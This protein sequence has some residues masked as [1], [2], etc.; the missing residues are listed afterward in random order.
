[1]SIR[2]RLGSLAVLAE[3]DGAA[4]LGCAV[5]VDRLGALH[6]AGFRAVSASRLRAGSAGRLRVSLLSLAAGAALLLGGAAHAAAP[7]ESYLGAET[8]SNGNVLERSTAFGGI[9]VTSVV[10]NSP[11]EVAGLREGDVI[12]RA[13]GI[14]ISHP[15]RLAE[16]VEKLP[17]GSRIRFR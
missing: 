15:I 11:A 17:P 5:R 12:L 4:G 16:V 10:E 1:W 8:K 6:A 2:R 3:R 9:T 14:E 13:N 7:G